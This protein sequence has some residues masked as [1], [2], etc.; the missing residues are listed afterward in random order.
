M[1]SP[2]GLVLTNS[3]VVDGARDLQLTDSEGRGM[4]ARLLGEDQQYVMK[5]KQT[6]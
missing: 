6:T 2:D 1:I 5:L 4:P 3:H